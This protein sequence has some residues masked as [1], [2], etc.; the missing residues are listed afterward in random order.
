M[1]KVIYIV[2]LIIIPTIIIAQSIVNTKHNLSVNGVGTVKSTTETEICLFCHTA[3]NSKPSSPLWNRNASG[4]SYTL[5]SSTTLKALPGQPSGSSILC[6][7]CHD[8]TIALGSVLSRG[9]VITFANTV[10]MPV[11]TSNLSTN[12]QN[13]HPISFTYDANLA[14]QNTQIISPASLNPVIKLEN[15]QLQCT[16]C[17]DPHKNIY[18][19]F[20]V[21]STQYSNICNACH[22][23][24][25]W[26]AGS[27][28]TATKTWNNVAP[29]P[30]PN[31]QWTTVAENACASCHNSHNAASNT[32]L[33][34]SL[35]EETV[36]L[37]CHNGNV[38][39]KN[40]QTQ[41][42]KTYRHN[43]YNYTGIHDEAEAAN[44]TTKHVECVD[45][46]NP[47][48]A[49][50]LAATAPNVSGS[51]IGVKGVNQ[52]GLAVA[53]SSYEYEICYK[54]HSSNPAT[55][56]TTSRVIIQNNVRLEFA[57]TNPSYHPIVG[58]GVNTNVPSLI[59][60]LTVTS[61]IY[62]SS[63]HAS[64]GTGAP[65]GPHGSIYPQIL[66]AQYKLTDNTTYSIAS[67]QLCYNCHSSTS[68][69]AN[70]SFKEHSKH[71]SSERTSCNTCH[72]S[73]GISNTQGNATNNSN[74]INFN[75][76]YVTPSSSGILRFDDQGL[77]KGRCYL[78]C[79]GENHN[80]YT[81]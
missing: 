34:N 76:L 9:T 74:L 73:H 80:P 67:F 72:D 41:L 59:S 39:G 21:A 47:H 54:C 53:S 24:T 42:A 2:A 43:V 52:S 64:D 20:L 77:Y 36:C 28:S 23:S 66:K 25:G 60:P 68:I 3:H 35:A 46:H 27:H 81:Y 51:L 11:G 15:S 29:N 5:Y 65:T 57:T 71:I 63:C 18:S 56:S 75:K 31:S 49:K 48:Q 6:L 40:I 8:G 4:A 17:H 78:T 79:H 30:W 19:D 22:Q 1:K 12:L 16:S 7:S 37:N 62:C 50:T 38:A 33:L 32:R 45:C 26:N 14:T 10:N 44:V 69:M 61:K 55:A 13:D 70:A 58:Q